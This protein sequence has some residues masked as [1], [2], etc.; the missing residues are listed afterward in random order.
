M[1]S[2]IPTVVLSSPLAFPVLVAHTFGTHHIPL[3]VCSHTLSIT[4]PSPVLGSFYCLR[5][6]NPHTRGIRPERGISLGVNHHRKLR[7]GTEE[8]GHPF[9]FHIGGLADRRDKSTTSGL[10]F[11]RTSGIANP[12]PHIHPHH[13][14]PPYSVCFRS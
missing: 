7:L 4:N 11:F 13:R 6:S 8:S 14:I 9:Q 12:A 3:H 10:V 5:A 1:P 2:R